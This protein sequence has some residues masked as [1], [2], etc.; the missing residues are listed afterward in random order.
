MKTGHPNSLFGSLTF[1]RKLDL[2]ETMPGIGTLTLKTPA[3]R[4]I[5]VD[6][7]NMI[8]YQECETDIAILRVFDTRSNPDENPY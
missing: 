8:Y 7:Y 4:K 2:I 3:V 5:R 6:Q 1:Y